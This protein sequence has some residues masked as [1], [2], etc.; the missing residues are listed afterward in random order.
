[1][2]TVSEYFEFA[3]KYI[4]DAPLEKRHILHAAH[5]LCLVPM[6]YQLVSVQ[7]RYGIRVSCKI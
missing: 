1:M 4:V 2:G 7:S 5:F 3:S 6:V